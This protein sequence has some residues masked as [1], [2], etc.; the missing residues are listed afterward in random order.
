MRSSSTL[1]FVLLL[2]L[3]LSTAHGKANAELKSFIRGEGIHSER[4]NH[5][6]SNHKLPE[7]K[8]SMTR[9]G[10]GAALILCRENGHCSDTDNVGGADQR[11]PRIHEDYYG[12]G[13][14]KSK[15][16]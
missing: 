13:D 6:G 14:H 9:R 16:H 3:L 4:Q 7:K 1:V 11:I 5:R 2:L 15:H 12:P 8:V 10:T